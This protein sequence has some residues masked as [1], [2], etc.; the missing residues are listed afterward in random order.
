MDGEANAT[1][2][3][4]LAKAVPD[5]TDTQK[6]E[7]ANTTVLPSVT[8]EPLKDVSEVDASRKFSLSEADAAL[9]DGYFDQHTRKQLVKF[10]EKIIA[11]P[12]AKPFTFGSLSTPPMTDR[13]L[14][15]QMHQVRS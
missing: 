10:Y 15:S 2:N 4:V 11:E 7:T 9:L 13:S 1:S 3:D 8:A 12:N 5:T 14:R 6:Q